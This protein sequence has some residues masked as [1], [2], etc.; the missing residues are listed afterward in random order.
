MVEN[1]QKT[2]CKPQIQ[3]AASRRQHPVGRYIADFYCHECKLIIELD[4]G[5]HNERKEYDENRDNYL[6][7]G[8]YTV[9]RFSND[10]IENSLET[11]LESIREHI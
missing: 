9:L 8:G 2:I 5:I 10:E 4:G 3:T 6:K 11:V 7:A 1:S